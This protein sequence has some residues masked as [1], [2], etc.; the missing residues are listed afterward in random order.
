MSTGYIVKL[1]RDAQFLLLSEA[2][3]SL[4]DNFVPPTS[5]VTPIFGEGGGVNRLTGSDL[6]GV[7]ASNVEFS[8]S[9]NIFG[10]S[11]G[12]NLAAFERVKQ[13]LK[14]TE[15]PRYSNLTPE[16]M[17]LEWTPNEFVGYVPKY[18]QWSAP[19]RLE[20]V[21]GTAYHSAN[22]GTTRRVGMEGV[23]ISLVCKPFPLGV[24]Q[25]MWEGYGG[26]VEPWYG[27]S[28]RLPQ[29]ISIPSART[30]L[31]TNP[32]FNGPTAWDNGWTA[33]AGIITKQNIDTEYV[34]FGKNS[35]E[36]HTSSSNQDYYQSFSVPASAH[37][38]SFF[39]RRKDGGV[40]D[41]NM[42]LPY[43]NGNAVL[44]SF[45]KLG[46]G[47]WYRCISDSFTG[48]GASAQI[49]V[50]MLSVTASRQLIMD[51]FQCEAGTHATEFIYGEMHGCSWDGA[52][53]GSSSTRAV[54]LLRWRTWTEILNRAPVTFSMIW[55]PSFD[56]DDVSTGT[57]YL[58]STTTTDWSFYYDATDRTFNW[59]YTTTK[60]CTSAAQTF[61]AFQ[62]IIIH[63]VMDPPNSKIY[64]NGVQSGSN[65]SAHLITNAVTV[66]LG[67]DT[68]PANHAN[69]I[70]SH[71][72]TW[73]EPLS[74]QQVADD[75]ANLSYASS[76]KNRVT[77]IPYRVVK[78]STNFRTHAV[79]DSTYS[80]YMYIGGIPGEAP[81]ITK[82]QVI[83]APHALT[84]AGFGGIFMSNLDTP[85]SLHVPSVAGYF[86]RELNGTGDTNSSSANYETITGVNSTPRTVLSGGL[87]VKE[88][89]T[90][91]FA[92][93]E[94]ALLARIKDAVGTNLQ[95]RLGYK[96]GTDAGFYSDWKSVDTST[97]GFLMRLTNF[98]GFK[99]VRRN[100]K[101]F[102]VFIPGGSEIFLQ[103]RRLS[104]TGNVDI[105]FVQMVPKPSMRIFATTTNASLSH[106]IYDSDLHTAVGARIVVG[107]LSIDS[108]LVYVE[109]NPVELVPNA[110]NFLVAVPGDIDRELT[111]VI[112]TDYLDFEKIIV[113]PR[114]G[115]L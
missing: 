21:W 66:L 57:H 30:N 88:E 60:R 48:T 67:S 50:R 4:E 89:S 83:G 73:T 52:T 15:H 31:F 87:A 92:G 108:D 42:C 34:L 44:G 27:N 68:T 24:P 37:R 98:L 97:G 14:L 1:V 93:K 85:V 96:I 72:A 28:D 55:Q 40:I 17:Y 45:Y 75:Y 13:F 107:K 32:T 113:I 7:T 86:Y 63:F 104:G 9:I 114:Y 78:D 110:K 8:F 41:G 94:F 5:N 20:V 84:T 12:E 26:I 36:I 43:Y 112:R 64:V 51:G 62:P 76:G 90:I 23:I 61:T 95:I 99:N 82:F 10:A 69:G 2:P 74:A 25:I 38:L 103:M 18:G 100:I 115:S 16:K 91:A 106:F 109:G 79:T 101:G 22:Y 54:S 39:V 19:R 49:G 56:S 105:D 11:E 53:H 58:L 70:I 80:N 77:S 59:S 111:D 81:A 65:G 6:L 35:L 102:D 71:F 29:G 33:D 47:P 3:Y 46:D